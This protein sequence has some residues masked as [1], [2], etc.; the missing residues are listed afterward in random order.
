[1]GRELKRVP[2]DFDWPTDKIWKGYDIMIKYPNHDCRK[3]QSIH[4]CSEEADYCIAHN[5]KHKET[6][7]YHPPTGEGFQMWETTSEGSPQSP[8]FKSLDELCEWL[9]NSKASWFGSQTATKDEWKKG[10]TRGSA[11]LL[12][13]TL[14]QGDTP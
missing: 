14:P 5:P 11:G 6:W 1:M 8:V 4:E 2:L 12:I 10:L 13:F 7:F 9:E 3:C